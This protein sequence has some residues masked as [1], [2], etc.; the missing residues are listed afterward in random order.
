MSVLAHDPWLRYRDTG[1]YAVPS[2]HHRQVFAQL[3]FEACYRKKFDVIAIELPPSYQHFGIIEA[4]LRLAPAPGMIIHPTGGKVE[5]ME[6]PINDEPNC[7]ETEL[8]PVKR[9]LSYPLTPCDSMVMALRCPHLLRERWPDWKPEIALIDAEYRVAERPYTTFPYRDDYEVMVDGLPKFIQRMETQLDAAR[10]PMVDDHRDKVMGSRLR[11]FLDQGMEVLFVCGAA[12]WRNICDYLDSEIKETLEPFR[13]EPAPRLIVAP[14]KPEIAW[15]WGWLDDMPRVLWELELCCQRGVVSDYD[16]RQAIQTIVRESFDE[17]REKEIPV[18][19]RRLQKLER[20]AS[21]LT[22]TVGRWIP[23]L[24]D[25]LVPAAEAC[26]EDRFAEVLKKQALKFPAPLP[27]GVELARVMPSE[28]GKWFVVAEDEV[29][30]LE[31]PKSEGKSGRRIAIEVQSGLTHEEKQT[32]E[33]E[34]NGDR[35]WPPEQ[36]LAYIMDSRARYL[37]T[38]Q[39]RMTYSRKFTGSMADGPDWRRTIRARASGENSVYIRQT[40]ATLPGPRARTPIVTPVVWIFGETPEITDFESTNAWIDNRKLAVT[41]LLYVCETV[42]LA[43]GNIRAQKLV[44]MTDLGYSRGH[45]GRTRPDVRDGKLEQDVDTAY[46]RSLPPDKICTRSV[47][48]DEE[49]SSFKGID[50]AIAAGV[51]YASD[52]VILVSRSNLPVA[53]VVKRYA[54]RKGVAISRISIDCFGPKRLERYR[55]FHWVPCPGS[56]GY[57]V[58]YEWCSRF[59]PPI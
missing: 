56:D 16:K 55:W 34:E 49:L 38:K 53:P 29:F 6:V 4:A 35:N 27:P 52:R 15:L 48:R 5:L 23:E 33:N 31:F 43:D 44:A 25:H 41:G 57:E 8:R 18:S 24:D 26:V 40:R 3:V 21:V 19:I 28:D 42:L 7:K 46:L 17:S 30:L 36:E 45:C 51:K 54:A 50:H 20:Y 59:V 22:S 1:L 39:E 12:H 11:R 58:P 37:A 32:I 13:A 47:W 14:I 2:I 10:C 9:G